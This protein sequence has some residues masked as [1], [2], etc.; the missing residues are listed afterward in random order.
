L[1]LRGLLCRSIAGTAL[2]G[3]ALT[4]SKE[5]GVVLYVLAVGLHALVFE[6]SPRAQRVRRL[7]RRWPLAIPP[8]LLIV[9]Y[10]ARSAGPWVNP[11][12]PTTPL[13]AQM[14]RLNLFVVLAYCATIFVLQFTWIPTSFV[15]AHVA[16]CARAALSRKSLPITRQELFVWLLFATAAAAWISFPTFVNARYFLPLA[17]LLLLCFASALGAIDPPRPILRASVIA[18][19]AALFLAS[20]FRTIDPLS[21]AVFGTFPFGKRSLLYMTSITHE[22]CGFG[23]DQMIYN[24]EFT[25]VHHLLEDVHARFPLAPG[26]RYASSEVADWHLMD[27]ID[28]GARR[29]TV[30]GRESSISRACSSDSVAAAA[31]RPRKLYFIDFP[32]MWPDRDLRILEQGYETN[33][34]E[35]VER[36]GYGLRILEMTARPQWSPRGTRPLL[37]YEAPCE[38]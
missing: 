13:I 3:T 6:L 2:A 32:F 28:G 33:R 4:F 30:D 10:L 15:V 31:V 11:V 26:I 18:A 21:R 22:C 16:L 5:P 34:V 17:P 9:F 37:P 23:R 1:T 27:R 36:G 12:H 8:L 24:L 35:W 29:R 25:Q 19:V 38:S 20:A 14:L 7:V